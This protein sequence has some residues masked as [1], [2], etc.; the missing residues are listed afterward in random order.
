MLLLLAPPRSHQ[1][2]LRELRAPGSSLGSPEVSQVQE[3]CLCIALER[4]AADRAGTRAARLSDV[5]L[6]G[7]ISDTAP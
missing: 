3:T 5:V 1:P 2:L 7:I 6:L 4:S